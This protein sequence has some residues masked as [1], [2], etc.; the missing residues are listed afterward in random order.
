MAEEISDSELLD[1]N[2]NNIEDFMSNNLRNIQQP[3]NGQTLNPTATR[4]K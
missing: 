1:L 3:Q 4:R 2:D